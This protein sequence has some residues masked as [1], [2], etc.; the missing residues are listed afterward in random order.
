MWHS[1]AATQKGSQNFIG[2]QNPVVDALVDKL[3]TTKD[4]QELLTVSRALD[5]VLLHGDYLV[6]NWY[7]GQHRVAYRDK[8]AQPA[9]VPLYYP[10]GESWMVLTWWIK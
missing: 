3:V 2:L 4:R 1:R 7:I 5:R 8:F 10:T 9:T 6:P